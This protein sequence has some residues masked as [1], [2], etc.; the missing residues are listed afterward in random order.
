MPASATDNELTDSVPDREPVTVGLNT[1]VM[2]QEPPPGRAAPQVPPSRW[3]SPVT[4]TDV[5]V[6]GLPPVLARVTGCAALVAPP[7]ALPK[8]TR[9]GLIDSAGG[10]GGTSYT[11]NSASCAAGARQRADSPRTCGHGPGRPGAAVAV[12]A[13]HARTGSPSWDSSP[14]EGAAAASTGT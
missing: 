13:P 5:S 12:P 6:A 14:E 3:K 2:V 11:S 4:V 1:T 9:P 7:A 8:L 10:A